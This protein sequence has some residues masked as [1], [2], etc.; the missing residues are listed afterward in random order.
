MT[1][2]IDTELMCSHVAFGNKVAKELSDLNWA[3]CAFALPNTAKLRRGPH[4]ESA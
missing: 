1:S 3:T 2:Y 4:L